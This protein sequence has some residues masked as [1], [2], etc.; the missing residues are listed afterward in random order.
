MIVSPRDRVDKRCFFHELS[1]EVYACCACRG[2]VSVKKIFNI[3]FAF[4]TKAIL[5]HFVVWNNAFIHHP[6]LT[7]VVSPLTLFI[8]KFYS[9]FSH[10]S[11][12]DAKIQNLNYN[13][14]IILLPFT[15]FILFC[16]SHNITR[17]T[18]RFY[19]IQHHRMKPSFVVFHSTQNEI[20]DV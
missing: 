14:Y 2:R 12:P 9:V 16:T 6:H 1:A 11:Q 18:E 3:S 19:G 15:V 7:P 13:R 8:R 4:A 20:Q 5:V 10:F 17:R